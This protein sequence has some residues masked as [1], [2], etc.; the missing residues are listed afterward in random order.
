MKGDLTNLIVCDYNGDGKNDF[1]R[2]EKGVWDDD[3]ANTA[4]VYLSNGNGTFSKQDLTDHVGMKG[5]LS[6]LIVGEFNGDRRTDFI[7]QEKGVW[8]DDTANNANIYLANSNGTFWKQDLTNDPNSMKADDGVNI[9]TGSPQAYLNPTPSSSPTPTGGKYQLPYPDGTTYKVYQGNNG[10]YSHSDQWNRYAWDFGMPE[11]N[12]V[13]ATR[14][15]KVVSLYEGSQ[16]RLTSMNGWAQYTNYVLI[17]HGDGTSS[18]Y[19]HLKNNSVLPNV[20]DYVSQNQPIAQSGNTGFSTDP[21]LHYSVQ[22]TPSYIPP[23][24]FSNTSGYATESLPSSFSDPNVLSQNSNGVP[25]SPNYY[26]S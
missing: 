13:V 7:R 3:T 17:D 14:S 11:G 6:N 4:Q 24:G 26:T 9:L 1:I 15:G 18:F 5:D 25:T 20:G 10:G 21:H 12:T 2:Q 16:T 23:G 22:K 19:S 8:D